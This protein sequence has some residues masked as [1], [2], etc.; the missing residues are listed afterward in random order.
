[1]QPV[2]IN[3]EICNHDGICAEVCPRKLIDFSTK[4]PRLVD[5]IE[6]MCIRCGHCM[7]VCPAAAISVAGVHPDH[8]EPVD[9]K[10]WASDGQL[11]HLMRSRRSIRAYRN[12]PVERKKI[13]RILDV[14]RFAPTGS[15]AQQVNWIIIDDQTRIRELGQLTVDW[16]KQAIAS[17]APISRNAPLAVIVEGW[18]KGE[19]RLFRSAP[20]LLITH[21]PEISSM[22]REN[23]I[24]AMTYFDLAA[25]SLGLGTCWIGLFMI[26][27]ANC[28]PLQRFL[29]IPGGHGLYGAMVAG[30]P[31]FAYSRIPARK[32]SQVKWQ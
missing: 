23:C 29:G 26:A 4:K 16:M 11:D 3:H 9:E 7:A 6:A 20:L 21:A 30:Y 5:G 1:M 32:E 31:R 19:D 18:E 14:C 25:F 13:E 24:I 2:V 10:Q 12:R 28:P 8:C 15:N 27:A 22:P 17:N